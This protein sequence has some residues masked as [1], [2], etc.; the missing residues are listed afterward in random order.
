MARNWAEISC[1]SRPSHEKEVSHY[2]WVWKNIIPAVSSYLVES[3]SQTVRGL[4]SFQLGIW[5][6]ET[7]HTP[8]NVKHK[9]V[10]VT[11]SNIILTVQPPVMEG[12][13]AA[14]NIWLPGSRRNWRGLEKKQEGG[15]EGPTHSLPSPSQTSRMRPHTL[16]PESNRGWKTGL[17]SPNFISLY[18]VLAFC[19]YNTQLGVTQMPQ[20]VGSQTPNRLCNSFHSISK[21]CN[22]SLCLMG[23]LINTDLT[24]WQFQIFSSPNIFGKNII[25][26]SSSSSSSDPGY[27]FICWM[28]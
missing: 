12:Q 22:I 17:L 2:R 8:F 13:T 7:W 1:R 6:L 5:V 11:G 25:K 9:S 19:F 4:Y 16:L 24:S 14:A 28:G 15:R 3:I 10:C 21:S 18:H 26:C 23:P 20:Q 27:L